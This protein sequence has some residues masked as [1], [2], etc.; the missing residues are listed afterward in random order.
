MRIFRR[1]RLRR[2]KQR[3]CMACHTAA[4]RWGIE[5]DEVCRRFWRDDI[6]GSCFRGRL[7][8]GTPLERERALRELNL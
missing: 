7:L 6:P 8:Y 4:G 3:Y 2:I 1:F 5:P